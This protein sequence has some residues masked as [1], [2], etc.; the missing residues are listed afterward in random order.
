[1]NPNEIELIVVVNGQ[2]VTVEANVNAP[3]KT[4]IPHALH[5][6]GNSGQPPENWELKDNDG[7]A[8][9]PNRKIEDFQFASGT[10]LF[11]SLKV[12][13]GG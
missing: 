11:L 9:D 4:I 6:S 1:V 10:T 3:V 7:N 8:L 12:G 2:A 5:E 13:I